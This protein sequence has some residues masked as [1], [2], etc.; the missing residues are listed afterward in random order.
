MKNA[1]EYY[2]SIE[3]DKQS[4]GQWLRR[5]EV[6]KILDKYDDKL[7]AS[8]KYAEGEW[9]F[10]DRLF[11]LYSQYITPKEREMPADVKEIHESQVWYEVFMQQYKKE[12]NE[13]VYQYF[14]HKCLEDLLHINY[15]SLL[16]MGVKDVW[17][18]ATEPVKEVVASYLSVCNTKLKD[19]NKKIDTH[20]MDNIRREFMSILDRGEINRR[21]RI[22][23]VNKNISVKMNYRNDIVSV[24]N[25]E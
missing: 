13:E 10:E 7:T 19:Y 1:T 25:E 9:Q 24:P 6:K 21:T 8:N 12:T 17:E 14:F 15:S 16:K 20:L 2:K 4:P 11:D 18:D 3:T 23:F 22:Y 5:K